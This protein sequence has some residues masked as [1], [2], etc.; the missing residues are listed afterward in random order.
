MIEMSR[1]YEA[2]GAI[3]TT[4]AVVGVLMNNR[5]MIA[6]FYLWIVSNFLCG[7]IHW[8]AGLTSLLIRDALFILLSL[9][10]I[11]RWRQTENRRRTTEADNNQ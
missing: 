11:W 8:Q 2:L 7:L 4:L 1:A 10:G 3:A 6:C 9:E 5:R